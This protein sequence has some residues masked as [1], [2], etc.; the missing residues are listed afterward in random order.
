M[1]EKQYHIVWNESK[2]E[3]YITDDADDAEFASVGWRAKASCSTLAQAM[4]ES[5]ANDD[6]EDDDDGPVELPTDTI[7]LEV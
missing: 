4:R 6:D 2:T 1:A 5:Y 3:G 7:T